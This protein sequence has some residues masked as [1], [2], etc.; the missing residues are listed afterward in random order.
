MNDQRRSLM[1]SLVLPIGVVIVLMV[2]IIP[3]PTPLLDLLITADITISLVVLL[4]ALAVTSP[5]QFSVFPSALLLLT[6]F[7][8]ALNIAST[9]LILLHGHTGGTAAGQVIAA[10]GQFVVGGNLAVGLVVFVVL[11]AV[12]FIVINHGATRISEV[13]A[14]FTL[15][16][17]PG[18]QMA[19]DAD[20][21]AG[22]INEQQARERRKAVADEAEFY[23]AMDGAVRFTQRDAIAAILI[24]AVNIIAGLFI[25][26]IQNGMGL[27]DA[28]Q[29]YTLLTVGDGLVTTIPALLISVAGGVVTTR[30]SV[31]ED[32]GGEMLKQ[33]FG[34]ASSLRIGAAVLGLFAIVPGMPRAAFLLMAA[35]ALAAA[36]VVSR[37]NAGDPSV[38]AS[39]PGGAAAAAEN[40]DEG[41]DP[42]RE[43]E[44]LLE[45]DPLTLEVGFGLVKL[46]SDDRGTGSVLE[47]IQGIR[48]QVAREM[49]FIMP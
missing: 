31:G 10:F 7:R 43:V 21:N 5:V 23:G 33:I 39:L 45:I 6:I 25:G 38:A 42:S 11:L 27:M 32:L 40:R 3:M 18:K 14:R 13:T 2:M 49:G 1:N 37:R 4:S 12:Q 29:T 34:R 48:R 19:I 9:R 30:A 24:T 17:L 46:V 47:K 44:S 26:A 41:A 28:L 8:L 22:L 15:D 20:L 16:A 36:R 35:A